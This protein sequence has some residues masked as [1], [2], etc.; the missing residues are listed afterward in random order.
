MA[1]KTIHETFWTDPKLKKLS[2][3]NRYLF[4]YLITCPSAHFSGLFYLP[5]KLMSVE[6]GIDD[7]GI[8]RGMDT[9]MDTQICQYDDERDIVFVRKMLKY[10][11]KD[12][13]LTETQKQG[14]INHFNKLHKT[15]LIKDF[16]SVW[17]S[18]ELKYI[19]TPIDTPM[20]TPILGV[21]KKTVTVNVNV[22]DEKEKDCKEKGKQTEKVNIYN[23]VVEILDY[24]N[25][26]IKSSY[27]ATTEKTQKTIQ[28][29]MNEGFT[30]ENFK[31]VIE[32][33]AAQWLNDPE[34]VRYLRPET[35]FGTK[36]ESYLNEQAVTKQKRAWED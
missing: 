20:D 25:S 2:P 13:N 22:N 16:L 5:E 6:T 15:P 36:F 1:Y 9:L 35:L 19:Y 24:L 26:Q 23:E 12:A 7:R 10:Q 31:T 32:K 34:M 17:S 8:G 18:L 3:I 4:C 21:S 29:R 27:K 33:K 14:L 28:A 11:I 30:V